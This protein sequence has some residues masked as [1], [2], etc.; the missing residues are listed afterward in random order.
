MWA[1][2]P[3]LIMYLFAICLMFSGYYMDL[4]FNEN[5][6]ESATYTALDEL[7]NKNNV[8]T[9]ISVDLIFGDFIAGVRVVFGILTGDTISGALQMFPS[10]NEVWMIFTRLLF[11]F[12]SA[13][14][15]VFVVTGRS[16]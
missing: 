6:F 5:L 14:L 2:K 1:G 12:S 11:T 10:F 7:M 15:W 16:I 4:I 8:D 9:T 3:A 13:M